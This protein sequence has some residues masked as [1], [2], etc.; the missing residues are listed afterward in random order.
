MTAPEFRLRGLWVI[1][2]A[3]LVLDMLQCAFMFCLCTFW[4]R[5]H[6]CGNGAACCSPRMKEKSDFPP[7]G[8]SWASQVSDDDNTRR[9]HLVVVGISI[10]YKYS[11]NLFRNCII[12]RINVCTFIKIPLSD[13]DPPRL[14]KGYMLLRNVLCLRL[15]WWTWMKCPNAY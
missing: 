5:H 7:V 9:E 1:L 15:N 3:L 4:N 11:E 12:F 13:D 14:L 2:I 6:T 8:S 10:K